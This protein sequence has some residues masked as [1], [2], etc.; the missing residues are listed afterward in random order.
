MPEFVRQLI[1]ERAQAR[2]DYGFPAC[3]QQGDREH[4]SWLEAPRDLRA[5]EAK[6]A[7]PVSPHP[8]LC[9]LSATA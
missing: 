5:P 6:I 7:R 8:R 2:A 3:R 1:L 4:R 9:D